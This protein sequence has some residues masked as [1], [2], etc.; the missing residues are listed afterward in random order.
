M[1]SS[2]IVFLLLLIAI[3]ASSGWSKTKQKEDEETWVNF[4]EASIFKK[5]VSFKVDGVSSQLVFAETRDSNSNNHTVYIGEVKA[6]EDLKELI[7]IEPI[8][9]VESSE[10]RQAFRWKSGIPLVFSSSKSINDDVN[11]YWELEREFENLNEIEFNDAQ[12]E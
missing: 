6:R 8:S 1:K 7:W 5:F 4:E 12:L 9:L 2:A 3:Q 10:S 11:I